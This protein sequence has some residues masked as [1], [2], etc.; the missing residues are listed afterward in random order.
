M[1]SFNKVQK[2]YPIKNGSVKALND[3]SFQIEAGEFLVIRGPSGCGKT[4]MLLVAGGL[5]KPTSGKVMVNNQDPYTMNQSMSNRLRSETIGFVFQQFHLIP[6][7]T[8]KENIL[9]PMLAMANKPAEGRLEELM[10]HFGLSG[11]E[12]H[13]PHQLSTGEKQRTAIAR[14]LFNKPKIIL[15]DEPTGNLDDENAELIY[16]YLKEFSTGGGS[17]LLVSHDKTSYQYGSRILEMRN[18]EFV[19]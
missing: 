13:L 11:R 18:G 15:A 19:N 3:V 1:I 8:V 5:L 9:A 2:E 4:T 7:L 17:V 12:D 10:L 14:A 16:K 6:Y